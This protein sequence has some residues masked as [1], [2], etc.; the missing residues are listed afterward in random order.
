VERGRLVYQRPQV[1]G[2]GLDHLVGA[3]H[4]GVARTEQVDTGIDYLE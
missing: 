3:S 4:R 1:F 2:G